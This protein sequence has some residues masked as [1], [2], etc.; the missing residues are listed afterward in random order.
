MLQDSL[1]GLKSLGLGNTLLDDLR[2]E[3]RD[4]FAVFHHF[5]DKA[6]THHLTVVSNGIIERYRIDGRDLSLIADR[7]PGQRRLTPVLRTVCSL[8]VR[9]TDIGFLVTHQRNL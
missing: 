5:L 7:H 9:H 8:G 6:R 4:G 1:Y 2:F 3:F